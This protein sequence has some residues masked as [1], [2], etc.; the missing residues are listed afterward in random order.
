MDPYGRVPTGSDELN[1]SVRDHLQSGAGAIFYGISLHSLR[2][3]KSRSLA[4]PERRA[5]E[6]S[7]IFR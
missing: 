2:S 5:K 6:A 1:A 3:R 7:V 4:A